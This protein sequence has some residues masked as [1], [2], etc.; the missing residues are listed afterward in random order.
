MSEHQSNQL[1]VDTPLL[2]VFGV[3]CTAP[4]SGYGAIEY[5]RVAQIA[6]PRRGVFVLEWRGEPVVVDTTTAVLLGAGDEYRVRHP[7]GGGDEGTILVVAPELL[8][9]ATGGVVGRLGPSASA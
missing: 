6:L 2:R 5:N 8:E 3:T 9:E 1:L 4:R 7:T